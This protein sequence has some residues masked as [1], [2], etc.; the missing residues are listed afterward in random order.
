M[1]PSARAGRNGGFAGIRSPTGCAT[2]SRAFPRSSARARTA[3]RGCFGGLHT[4]LLR[5]GIDARYE[6][7]GVLWLATE[8]Y[9][10]EG[11]AEEVELSRARRRRRALDAAAARAES[12][13]RARSAASGESDGGG[14]LDPVAPASG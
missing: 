1:S 9:Q 8:R 2:A 13:R 12:P 7:T 6:A 10:V 5:H 3:G 4:S 11:I 14:L